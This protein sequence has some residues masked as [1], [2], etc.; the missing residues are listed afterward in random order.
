MTIL[1]YL[2]VLILLKLDSE[3]EIFSLAEGKTEL[4]TQ[5]EKRAKLLAL[6][7]KASTIKLI[8]ELIT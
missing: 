8:K 1:F 7:S 2:A 4:R 3:A 6:N 5:Y